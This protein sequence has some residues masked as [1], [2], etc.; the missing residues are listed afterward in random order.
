ML[1]KIFFQKIIPGY[2]VRSENV[3]YVGFRMYIVHN[4]IR[5]DA[6]RRYEYYEDVKESIKSNGVVL[7]VR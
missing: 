7:V 6:I 3:R 5:I 1:K 2:I 4:V